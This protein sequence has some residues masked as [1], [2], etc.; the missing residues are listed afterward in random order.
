[1]SYVEASERRRQAV[2]AARAVMTR[3]GVTATTLRGVAAEAGIPLGTLQYV[4][5]TRDLLIE[6]VVEDVVGEIADLLSSS[7][8]TGGGLTHAIR[9]GLE[10]FWSTL[11]ADQVKLQLMQG[12]L[13]STSL[14]NPGRE[15]L[16]R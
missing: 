4:F 6:A 12:E 3:R 15:H 14:R 5:P 13:L 2:A 10:L 7:L 16:A 8:P 11:V 1:M 9:I